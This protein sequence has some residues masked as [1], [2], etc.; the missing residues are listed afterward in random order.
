MSQ[1]PF[2]HDAPP[3]SFEKARQL[4]NH[5]TSAEQELWKYLRRKQIDGFRFRRQHPVDHFILD[6][7]C[8]ESR[9]AIEADGSV[10]EQGDQK[11]YDQERD[12]IIQELGIKV[13]RFKNNEIFNSLPDVLD[14]IKTELSTR[15]ELLKSSALKSSPNGEDLGGVRA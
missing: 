2:F 3:D 14:K 5:V 9:L 7:Y 13:L 1:F 8:H 12:R 15:F 10:H 6:F 4:R 11:L